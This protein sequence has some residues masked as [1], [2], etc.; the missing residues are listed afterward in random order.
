MLELTTKYA[1]KAM[2]YLV[3]EAPPGVF[4]QVR[5]ISEATGVPFPY[6][7]KVVKSIAACGLVETRRGI[8]GGVRMP[9]KSRPISFYDVCKALE[10]PIATDHCFLSRQACN[11]RSPCPIHS[12]WKK[13]RGD[14]VSFLK[15]GTLEGAPKRRPKRPVE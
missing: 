7:S 15:E 11:L 9:S 5:T 12:R 2:M 6:M 3:N 14:L 4:V 10:D 13:V 8:S 1:L